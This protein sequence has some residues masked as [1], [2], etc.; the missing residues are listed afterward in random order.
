MTHRIRAGMVPDAKSGGPLGGS[1]K[2]LESD[3]TFVGGKKKNV[4]RGKPEPKKHAVH[5]LVERGGHVRAHHV[6]DVTAK[7]LR[8]VL[9]K[10]ADKRSALHTDD[11][12]ANLSLGKDFAEH[13]T[14][15]HTLGEYVTK[16]GTAHTQTVESFFAL[17]KRQIYGTHHAVS[18]AHLQ[19]YVSEAAFRWNHRASLGVNDNARAAAAIKAIGGKRLT[20]GTT[21]KDRQ[22]SGPQA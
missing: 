5:A 17:I 14:V 18:E 7:T 4:H 16:D 3:E 19:R 10:Q 6:A 12:L 1:G 13:K 20:Y 2:V 21:R 22:A 9:D 8:E 11:S 15:A